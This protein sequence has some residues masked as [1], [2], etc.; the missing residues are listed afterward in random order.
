MLSLLR[1]GSTFGRTVGDDGIG[2]PGLVHKDLDFK[3][4][5]RRIGLADAALV[6]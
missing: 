5:Q 1:A 3:R 6:P 4:M 2:A